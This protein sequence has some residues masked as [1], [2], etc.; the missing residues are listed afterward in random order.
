MYQS[1]L[2]DSSFLDTEKL[3]NLLKFLRKGPPQ[4]ASPYNFVKR[5]VD[6]IG[7]EFFF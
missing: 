6:S 7:K 1:G 4:K 3:F 2:E 5:T